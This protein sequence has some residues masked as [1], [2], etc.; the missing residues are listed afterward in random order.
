MSK[1]EMQIFRRFFIIALKENKQNMSNV[2]FTSLCVL[3]S[4]PTE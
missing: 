3:R 4:K 1:V 2:V